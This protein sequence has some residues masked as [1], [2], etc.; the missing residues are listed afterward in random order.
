MSGSEGILVVKRAGP[1][2]SW[3]VRRLCWTASR[4]CRGVERKGD[5]SLLVVERRARDVLLGLHLVLRP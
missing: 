2:R 1:K 5:Y 4:A 3:D